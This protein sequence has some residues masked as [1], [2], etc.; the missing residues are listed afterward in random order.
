MNRSHLKYFGSQLSNDGSVRDE[1]PRRIQQ[2]STTFSKLY[3]R[4]CK[5]KHVKIK[6]KIKTDKT[7]KDKTMIMP[8][9][10]YGA[11][12]WSCISKQI[13]KLNELQYRHLRTTSEKFEEI[14]I[15]CSSSY[16]CPIWNKP[17]F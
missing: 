16:I 7:R 17:K 1:I 3:Q 13:A 12:T 6:T 8:C 15:S 5:K 14:N 9:L 10:H 2:A 11:E 4:I